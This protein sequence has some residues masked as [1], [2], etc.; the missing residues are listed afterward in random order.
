MGTSS[1]I[2]V[3]FLPL[4][5][6]LRVLFICCSEASPARICGSS[7]VE[8][9]GALFIGHPQGSCMNTAINAVFM[10]PL[11]PPETSDTKEVYNEHHDQQ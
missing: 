9:E 6:R 8:P 10:L 2:D 7:A 11:Y 3:R 1:T 4:L 5:E